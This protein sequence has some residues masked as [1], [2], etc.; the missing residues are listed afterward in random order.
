MHVENVDKL[1][2]T[3]KPQATI[4]KYRL[5]I[6]SGT[7]HHGPFISVVPDKLVKRIF[8]G[9]SNY[10]SKGL[11]ENCYFITGTLDEEKKIYYKEISKRIVLGPHMTVGELCKNLK[12]RN[13]TN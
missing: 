5:R 4:E 8:R 10:R 11:Y 6:N 13:G 3:G 9:M 7:K 1:L 2:I 12:N